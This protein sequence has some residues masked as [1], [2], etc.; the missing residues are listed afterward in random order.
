MGLFGGKEKKEENPYEAI[1]RQMQEFQNEIRKQLKDL[2]D[3]VRKQ[4]EEMQKLATKRELSKMGEGFAK[5]ED[6][7]NARKGLATTDDV[8]N[9]RK[10]LA[11]EQ[12]VKDAKKDL[13]AD[14]GRAVERV[15]ELEK[16][17]GNLACKR[18]ECDIGE[19]LKSAKTSL[20][21]LKKASE[22]ADKKIKELDVEAL[23]SA[24]YAAAFKMVSEKFST[25]LAEHYKKIQGEIDA[26]FGKE[27]MHA[28]LVEHAKSAIGDIGEQLKAELQIIVDDAYAKCVGKIEELELKRH[29]EYLKNLSIH[30][31]GLLKRIVSSYNDYRGV[32]N[33]LSNPTNKNF[34]DQKDWDQLRKM[35]DSAKKTGFTVEYL[36]QAV[37]EIREAKSN[38]KP[39]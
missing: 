24:V 25:S 30:H 2:D 20:N 27:E 33:A 7:A 23:K 39:S 6:V 17:Y 16:K 15:E 1:S 38:L 37:Q 10:G 29:R 22:E 31:Q 28:R 34:A 8:A 12:D 32:E 13:M 19:D 4:H 14:L 11:S 9:A 35:V 21:D 3:R 36:Y 26:I 18:V 5:A